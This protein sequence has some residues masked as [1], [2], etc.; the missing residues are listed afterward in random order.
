MKNNFELR[1]S[2]INETI[3]L[4]N[5]KGIK[6]N[7]PILEK[8][9]NQKFP[10]LRITKSQI[11]KEKGLR[12]KTKENYI[13][14]LEKVDFIINELLDLL[15]KANIFI[16]SSVIKQYVDK[17]YKEYGISENNI[18]KSKK[19]KI[20]IK[21]LNQLLFEKRVHLMNEAIS[22]L[23]S[24]NQKIIALT[25]SNYIKINF[26]NMPISE[27]IILK[28]SAL[29]KNLKN[30]NLINNKWNSCLVE[31]KKILTDIRYVD[32]FPL[33][34]ME[35]I[36]LVKYE[37]KHSI[38]TLK[39]NFLSFFIKNINNPL[40]NTDTKRTIA[41]FKKYF[42]KITTF[43]HIFSLLKEKKHCNSLRE[44]SMI[45][46]S[47]FI[48]LFLYWLKDKEVLLW[49]LE[50]TTHI[51]A[52]GETKYI[53]N[54]FKNPIIQEMFIYKGKNKNFTLNSGIKVF[55][56]TSFKSIEAIRETD[57][58]ELQKLLESFYAS[59]ESTTGYNLM[60]FFRRFIS[61]HSQN[62]KTIFQY[63]QDK[64]KVQK[65]SIFEFRYTS[66]NNQIQFD[67]ISIDVI[68]YLKK[69]KKIDKVVKETLK[70]KLSYINKFLIY[71]EEKKDF[72]YTNKYLTN[73]FDYPDKEGTFQQLIESSTKLSEE[74]KSNI[75]N[76]VFEFIHSIKR[77]IC[78]PKSNKPKGL[79]GKAGSGKIRKVLDD[80]VYDL[81]LDIVKNDPPHSPFSWQNKRAD[82]SWWKHRV[83]PAL[84]LMIYLQLLIP[85]RG[86]QI[87]NL[88]KDKFIVT[89]HSGETIGFYINTDKNKSRKKKF[90]VPNIWRSEMDIFDSYIKWHEE[91]FPNPRLYKYNNEDN[92]VHEDFIPLFYAKNETTPV[93]P[94]THMNYWKRVLIK[95]QITLNKNNPNKKYTLIFSKNEIDFFKNEEELNKADDSFLFKNYR[96]QF[97]IHSLR[98]TGTTRYIRMGF[99]ISIVQKLTGHETI[100]TLLNIYVDLEQEDVI[101]KLKDTKLHKIVKNSQ[102]C[103]KIIDDRLSK[104]ETIDKNKLLEQGL[105]FPDR[106]HT[107]SSKTIEYLISNFKPLNYGI[108]TRDICPIGIEN[109][110]SL[111]PHLATGYE[112]IFGISLQ[113][114]LKFMNLVWLSNTIVENRKSKKN[115]ENATLRQELKVVT[116]EFMGWIDI[117]ENINSQNLETSNPLKNNN[118]EIESII[119]YSVSKMTIAYAKT[120]LKSKKLEYHDITTSHLIDKFQNIILKQIA[121][122]ELEID[123]IKLL[124]DKNKLI[125]W[126]IDKLSI[127]LISN[128]KGALKG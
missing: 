114:E 53:K 67:K 36:I 35:K 78:F 13:F 58:L 7:V 91:Y 51:S 25:I 50:M 62:V 128:N 108:C 72:T 43:N 33:I 37:Y 38:E 9:I 73:I 27:A 40:E 98:K 31:S 103:K 92:Q 11:Y 34:N 42:F 26:P 21:K 125:E 93:P 55:L 116:E 46:F 76:S 121:N 41:K 24:K 126:Y 84:P 59:K 60:L 54:F 113:V 117:I 79:R 83:Y 81:I 115:H 99:P 85:L 111:C 100:D 118:I 110:C 68:K 94:S 104:H 12:L 57:L 88:N 20:K 75:I 61:F 64:N 123:D 77:G 106:I 124:N 3:S 1:T 56:F 28:D 119:K 95:A 14:H 10:E 96:A 101:E 102:D 65:K 120:Y 69:K 127:N 19:S 66:T 39:S 17:Y 71:L 122:N 112:F 52:I 80:T 87:R 49:S 90:I 82:I 89:N 32:S 107:E 6:I 5:K 16:T 109:K 2:I 18:V 70:E 45:R 8:V 15:S 22:Y 23:E 30:F 47:T 74:Q 105:F 48:R 63:K 97:D 4:F 29:Q 86:A 44:Y